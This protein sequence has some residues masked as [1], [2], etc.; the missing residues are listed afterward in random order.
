MNGFQDADINISVRERLCVNI[1]KHGLDRD[2]QNQRVQCTSSWCPDVLGL[3]P[4]WNKWVK[5]KKFSTFEQVGQR[6]KNSGRVLAQVAQAVFSQP[7]YSTLEQVAQA[8]KFKVLVQNL[9]L[10]RITDSLCFLVPAWN[11]KDV[12]SS[13]TSSLDWKLFKSNSIFRPKS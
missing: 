11:C 4:R 12:N 6:K 3:T 10:L 2:C 1:C 7:E 13:R 8:V 5:A 9:N